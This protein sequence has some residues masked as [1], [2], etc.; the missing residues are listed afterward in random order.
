MTSTNCF[1]KKEP[2]DICLLANRDATTLHQ[3]QCAGN[4]AADTK[5]PASSPRG[6]FE[7][8]ER[9]L[10]SNYG[11]ITGFEISVFLL[12]ITDFFTISVSS[13][14]PTVGVFT[15]SFCVPTVGKCMVSLFI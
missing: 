10:P 12:P 4:G 5:S 2:S 6:T 8:T 14:T 11:L 13:F 7:L 3:E 9:R 15:V 1:L